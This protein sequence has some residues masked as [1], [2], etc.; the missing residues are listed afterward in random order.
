MAKSFAI[1][2]Y[3]VLPRGMDIRTSRNKH[4]YFTLLSSFHFRNNISEM[5]NFY[6]QFFPNWYVNNW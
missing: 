3:I 6:L 2:V 4:H 1:T 5:M